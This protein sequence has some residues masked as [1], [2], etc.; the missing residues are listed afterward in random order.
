MVR[1]VITDFSSKEENFDLYVSDEFGDN[2]TM[3]TYDNFRKHSVILSR[4]DVHDDIYSLNLLS[5]KHLDNNQILVHIADEEYY[6]LFNHKTVYTAKI[7]PNFISDDIMKSI[8]ITKHIAMLSSGGEIEHIYYVA[9]TKYN[10]AIENILKQN[11]KN[12]KGEV[13]AESLGDVN[14]LIENLNPLDTINTYSLKSAYV[15]GLLAFIATIVFYVLPSIEK[16]YIETS[17]LKQIENEIKIQK[18][19]V[20]REKILLR[21]AKRKHKELIQCISGD[22]K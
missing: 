16:K 13:I 10:A 17:S 7:N 19:L 6:I 8:L 21:T 11:T 22:L 14:S 5:K 15:I 18:R 9:N 4:Y 3:F 12:E 2:Q 20:V 1:L